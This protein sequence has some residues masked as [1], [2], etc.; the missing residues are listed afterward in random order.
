MFFPMNG[1]IQNWK[2]CTNKQ[3]IVSSLRSQIARDFASLPD[4]FVERALCIC[5]NR[6]HEVT[7]V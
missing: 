3:D 6:Q 2:I 1:G 7:E 5:K 4:V